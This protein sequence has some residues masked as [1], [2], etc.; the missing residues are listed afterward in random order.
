MIEV[1]IVV[2]IIGLL[3]SI[4]IPVVKRALYRAKRN[5]AIGALRVLRDDLHRYAAD[6]GRY[7]L[8]VDATTLAPLVPDYVKRPSDMLR[9]LKGGKLDSYL[10]WNYYDDPYSDDMYSSPTGFTLTG[11]LAYDQKTILYITDGSMWISL[12]GVSTRVGQ[13]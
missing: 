8:T 4:A 6:K 10:A 3:A 9:A 13:N 11:T 12:D 5:A 7:P 2:A 1:L